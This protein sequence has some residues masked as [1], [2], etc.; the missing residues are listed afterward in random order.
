MAIGTPVVLAAAWDAT[1]AAS[2]TTASLAVLPGRTLVLWVDTSISAGSTPGVSPSNSVLTPGC[3]WKA[4][5]DVAWPTD[6]RH[7]FLF[8]SPCGTQPIPGRV[9]R[10]VDSR[11]DDD[12]QLVEARH[13]DSRAGTVGPRGD[14]IAISRHRRRNGRRRADTL[15]DRVARERSI[16][17][18]T[19]NSAATDV[20]SPRPATVDDDD[21]GLG[22]ALLDGSDRLPRTGGS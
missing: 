11:G 13:D 1:D 17:R 22:R 7:G 12:Q 16:L 20:L 21:L 5:N 6:V 15:T 8:T 10:G 4:E 2:Y 18:C 9:D 14:D 19:S 3:I